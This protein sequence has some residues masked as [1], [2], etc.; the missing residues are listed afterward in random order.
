M[1]HGKE[2]PRQKMIGMMYLVLTALLAL[3]VSK[4]VLDAFVLVEEGLFKTTSNFTAQNDLLYNAFNQ[5]AAENQAK[6]GPWRDKALEVKKMADELYEYIQD[7]K[8]EIVVTAEGAKSEAIE[9]RE[10][11]GMKISGKDNTDVP[12]QIMVGSNFTGKANDLKAAIEKYKEHIL[13]LVDESSTNVISSISKSLD[14]SNPPSKGTETKTWQSENFTHLPLIA[15]LTL[16][17]KMQGDVRNAES[18]I[19]RYLFGRIDAGSFKF[20]TLEPTV[21]HNSNYVIRGNE[22][23]AEIF[24]AAFDTTQAPVVLVGN[25]ERVTNSDGSID[26]VMKGNFD[27]LRVVNGR[28]I[29]T[30]TPTALGP[31]SWGGLIKIKNADGSFT[32][33]PFKQEYQVAEPS[34]VVSPTKMNVFYVGVDNPVDISVAGVPADKIFPSITNGTIRKQGNSYIVNPRSPGNSLVTVEVD[35]GEGRRKNMGYMEFRVRTVPDPVAKVA[36]RTGGAIEKNLLVAQ[37]VVV[38]DLPNFE[39][40]LNFTVTGF[41]VSTTQRGF[42]RDAVSNNNRITEEQ[43]QIFESLARNQRVYIQDIKAIGPDGKVRE[44]PTIS[45][46]IN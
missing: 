2:T 22:Y 44:L 8:L 18:E 46:R 29:Y 1:G 5:S 24:V 35:F 28:G 15:V 36:G 31:V 7:L 19:L 38:A 26:Y 43:K 9:G 30:R 45:F 4:E 20:N 33:R 14:T 21:I 40:D 3:N 27:S 10:I 16:M 37:N 25:Y 42:V 12:A 23:K 32:T 39:F 17:S 34:L 11:H 41:T 6:V 13:G